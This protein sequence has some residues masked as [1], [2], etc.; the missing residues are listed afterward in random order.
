MPSRQRAATRSRTADEVV[1]DHRSD[2]AG[3]L[4]GT[5]ELCTEFALTPRAIRFYEDKGPLAP[6][7]VNGARVHTRRDRS[8][9]S[10]IL[11]VE[12][13]GSSPAQISH[14]LDL[15]GAQ[16]EGR[17]V[18]MNSVLDGTSK[19]LAELSRSAHIDA[20]LAE[21]RIIDAT[22]KRGLGK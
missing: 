15:Y 16:G 18:Q 8:R 13:S 9:L 11:H 20:S 22:V 10:L 5:S 7:R 4:F 19:A 3:D 14:C 17:T 12:A 1:A 6:R 21:F 2:D